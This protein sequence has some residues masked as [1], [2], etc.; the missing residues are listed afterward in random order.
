MRSHMQGN[1]ENLGSLGENQ[2]VGGVVDVRGRSTDA[3]RPRDRP[4]AWDVLGA[5]DRYQRL[6]S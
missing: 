5:D 2:A 3:E 1:D 6:V 4:T